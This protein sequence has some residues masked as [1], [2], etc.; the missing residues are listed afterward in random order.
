MVMTVERLAR[1]RRTILTGTLV[2]FALWQGGG[3]ARELTP[4]SGA[5]RGVELAGELVGA[6]VWAV[7]FIRMKIWQARTVGAI[8]RAVADELWRH[9]M[10][11][12]FAVAFFAVAF[13]Q[14]AIIFVSVFAPSP[15]SALLAARIS[16]YV[17]VLTAIGTFLYLDRE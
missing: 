4:A 8:G 17:A 6:V 3:I 10:L 1:E 12:S 15:P 7:F 2:G 16:I 13:T 11:V 14:A 5:A 9:R